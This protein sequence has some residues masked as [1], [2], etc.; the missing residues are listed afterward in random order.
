MLDSGNRQQA[1]PHHGIPTPLTSFVGRQREIDEAV[2]LLAAGR[3]VTLVGPPGVGKTRLALAI[4][5][6]LRGRFGDGI[7]LVEL[8]GLAEPTLVAQAIGSCFGLGDQPG[9]TTT[10]ALVDFLRDRDLLVVL[11]NCEH[12]IDACATLAAEVLGPSP[13]LRILATS[14]EGLRIGGETVV[15]VP[16]LAVPD[17]RTADAPGDDE[18]SVFAANDA[19]RL[20][21]DRARAALPRFALTPQNVAAVAGICRRLDGLPLAIEL[22]AARVSG[23]TPEQIADRLDASFTLLSAGSRTALPRQQ[24]LRG[25]VDWSYALLSEPEQT[26]LR[27]LSVFAGGWTLEAAEAVAGDGNTLGLLLSL[28][29]KSLVQVDGEPGAEPRYRLLETM[30]QYGAEKLAEHGDG[31]L[32][33][34]RHRDWFQALAMRGAR[35]MGGANARAWFDRLETEHDNFRAAL[36]WCLQGRDPGDIENALRLALAI[37]WFWFARDHLSEGRWWL[38]RALDADTRL[39][40]AGTS[41]QMV[42]PTGF[43]SAEEPQQSI[44]GYGWHLRVT[45]LNQVSN[46]AYMQQDREAQHL[47]LAEVLE[48]GQRVGDTLG[49]AHAHTALGN[50]HRAEGEYERSAELLTESLRLFRSLGDEYGAW[51]SL[52]NLSETIVMLGDAARASELAD[53]GRRLAVANDHPWGVAQAYRLLGL[54]AFRSGDHVQAEAHLHEAI[55]RWRALAVTRGPHWAHCELGSVLLARDEPDR[56]SASFRESLDISHR[57][58]D[59]RCVAR[60]L[61]GL[62]ASGLALD[63]GRSGHV[64]NR[65]TQLLGAAAAIRDTVKTPVSPLDRQTYDRAVKTATDV[66]GSSAFKVAH[67]EGRALT[68]DQAVALAGE[69][70]VQPAADLPS[71]GA[72]ASARRGGHLTRREREVA[73]LVGAGLTNREI[74]DRLVI[75]ERTAEGHVANILARLELTRRSQIAAWAVRQEL[76]RPGGG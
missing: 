28:V 44:N 51:R 47:H 42:V 15:R 24:T 13:G 3:L 34:R 56:A 67:D 53:E 37:Q 69:V 38:A 48:L 59:R 10:A 63:G 7:W 26:L 68:Q 29:D 17:P 18:L 4:A 23:L 22:A 50:L 20:F 21:V 12:L 32:V 27:R 30:R 16:A 60:N 2:E 36:A 35:D 74:A 66:L 72:R 9:R 14:R 73:A 52:T 62:A 11:D 6:A 65:A 8:A 75:S 49:L 76:A 64:A 40:A 43:S 31:D 1:A 5:D 71:A 45:A 61:E 57:A 46:L 54:A 19:V 39:G 58:G 33:R 25:A 55:S 41:G 70:S